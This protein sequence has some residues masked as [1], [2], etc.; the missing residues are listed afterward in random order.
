M[1]TLVVAGL[2]FAVA[3]GQRTVS[4]QLLAVPRVL[5]GATP[6]P[7]GAQV[8]GTLSRLSDLSIDLTLVP[9]HASQL[10][11][12]AASAMRTSASPRRAYLNQTQFAVRFGATPS[13]MRTVQGILQRAGITVSSFS[14][15]HLL[16][17][18][19]GSVQAIERFFS[20]KLVRVR[21][22]NATSPP[23]VRNLPMT[24]STTGYANSTPVILPASLARMVNSVVGFDGL[25][26]EHPADLRVPVTPN[27]TGPSPT[28]NCGSP[29]GP[30]P[31]SNSQAL[32][33]NTLANSYGLNSLYGNSVGDLGAGE[34]V[35]L[36]EF[37]TYNPVDVAAFAAC[38]SG[39]VTGDVSQCSV[40]GVAPGGCN[41]TLPGPGT[42]SPGGELEADL[43][44]E[45]VLGLAPA[46]HVI[47]YDSYNWS[48][49]NI[50]DMYNAAI[51]NSA[52]SVISTSWGLCESS[53]GSPLMVSESTLFEEAIVLGKTVVAASG[54]F[55]SSDCSTASPLQLQDPASQPDV[56]AVG[57]TTFTSPTDTSAASGWG[58]QDY[59]ISTSAGSGHLVATWNGSISIAA[60][61]TAATVASD[62]NLIAPS[63]ASALVAPSTTSSTGVNGGGVTI[64]TMTATPVSAP[65]RLTFSNGTLS[66]ALTVKNTSV[67]SGGG[68][69][70]LWQM[71]SYQ[72]NAASSLGVL[73]GA[74]SC[75]SYPSAGNCREVPDVAADAGTPFW[76]YDTSYGGWVAIKGTSLA[77]PTWGAMLA[78]ANASPACNN[79]PVGFINPTLYSIA[80]NPSDAGDLTD[81]TTGY[82]AIDFLSGSYN[83]QQYQA[84][85]G[86]DLVTG[87]GTPHAGSG[88]IGGSGLV[89]ALCGATRLS[90]ALT[91]VP[92]SAG[93][94]TTTS[95]TTASSTSTSSSTTSTTLGTTTTSSTTITTSPTTTTAPPSNTVSTPPVTTSPVVVPKLVVTNMPISVS[96]TSVHLQLSCQQSSCSG[97]ATLVLPVQEH[98][99]RKGRNVTITVDRVIA[100]SRY[101]L[102]AR[103]RAQ[104]ALKTSA[105][106]HALLASPNHTTFVT[107]LVITVMRGA[108]YRHALRILRI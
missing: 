41:A 21:M 51:S 107:E 71:P 13:V 100:S 54:D 94:T 102:K 73:S 6:L 17:S 60:G 87:L 16:V 14:R 108:T 48:D 40:D 89:S 99:M 27:A 18:A 66:N 96:P 106:G 4:A 85:P 43:D 70:A 84:T 12:L 23:L 77:A 63:G 50:E 59:Q 90:T 26:L 15:S 22:A 46:A 35:A 2:I 9:Q 72:Q 11:Q 47:T 80:A 68:I 19:H 95:T 30:G 69:S 88:E 92:A 62:L 3:P 75:T 28:G 105:W 83:S 101:R 58:E 37:A 103:S 52:V 33:V 65:T 97:N 82:N 5:T 57:G 7:N 24:V 56:L 38:Y 76:I 61:A 31:L 79:T 49:K 20:T 55:G 93:T 34:T 64:W 32:S 36:I 25:P 91:E 10:T 45:A 42:N 78:L 1:A 98:V 67:G 53:M 81:V 29:S 86:Y 39:V 8:L 44:V 74:S 104:V